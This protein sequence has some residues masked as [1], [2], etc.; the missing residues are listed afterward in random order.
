MTMGTVADD[1]HPQ[2]KRRT[3]RWFVVVIAIVVAYA[4]Q[5]DCDERR[6]AEEHRLER[7]R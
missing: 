6:H 5:R 3:G 7:S 4:V 1:P 2:P